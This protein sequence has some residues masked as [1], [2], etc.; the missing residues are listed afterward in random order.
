MTT[1]SRSTKEGGSETVPDES[2]MERDETSSIRE[3]PINKK[4]T[5][6]LTYAAFPTVPSLEKSEMDL[7]SSMKGVPIVIQHRKPG[8]LVTVE[9]ALVKAIVH[10]E[11]P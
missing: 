9:P 3:M 6:R 11:P 10:T 2:L 8:N 5:A 7:E 4:K 1:D